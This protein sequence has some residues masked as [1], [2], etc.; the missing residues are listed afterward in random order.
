MS[1]VY[2]LTVHAL[3]RF[4]CKQTVQQHRNNVVTFKAN[5]AIKYL[6]LVLHSLP[7]QSTSQRDCS[8]MCSSIGCSLQQRQVTF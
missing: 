7:F 8:L 3:E 4:S 6:N 5:F 2:N 1:S